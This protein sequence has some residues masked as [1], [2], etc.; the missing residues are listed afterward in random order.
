MNARER[1]LAVM[2]FARVDRT[3]EWEFGY[4][5]ETVERWY[6]E[7]LPRG[8]G[9]PRT[10][11]A[12]ET[13]GGPALLDFPETLM[14]KD[15][16]SYF[17]FDTGVRCLPVKYWI[18]PK[19]EVV[20]VEEDETTQVF[21]DEDGI[22][23]RERKDRGTVPHFVAGPVGGR[24][25]WE[26][27]KE[28][29]FNIQRVED[30]FPE[31]WGNLVRELKERD[32]PIGIGGHPVGFFGGLRELLGEVDVHY[33]YYDD[34]KLLKDILRHLTDLWIAI[35][36]EILSTLEVDFA[37]FW[38][39]MAYKGGSLISPRL[40][41]EFMLPYYQEIT[42]FLKGRGIR[43]LVVD[44]DGNCTELIPLFLEAGLTGMY[45]FE[46][47]AGMNIVEV[48]KSYPGLQIWGGLDKLSAVEG[49]EGI[50]MELEKVPFMLERGGYIPFLD[51]LVPPDVSWENYRFFRQELKR[52]N[53]CD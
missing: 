38:E 16:S 1:F 39:D 28:E 30:R 12:G 25:D 36:E 47:Q 20:M 18:Y 6:K 40:V 52:L 33:A 14:D 9:L 7:G 26:K 53:H 4:W 10:P 27:V 21:V 24:N 31:N 5:G 43:H 46:V 23:R 34:P 17:G 49:R 42:G 11:R 19:F 45:P 48:R 35:Y 15:V 50:E 44:T 8:F 32:Y 51:H 3:L 41:R 37:L 22:K 29:R 2:D 13:V